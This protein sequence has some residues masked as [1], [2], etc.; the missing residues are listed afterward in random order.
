MSVGGREKGQRKQERVERKA[1]RERQTKNKLILKQLHGI[2]TERG[3]PKRSG[4]DM[5][6]WT[7][8]HGLR[9]VARQKLSSKSPT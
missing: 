9:L 5:L 2:V 4:S 8:S 3:D 6:C 1:D 7:T